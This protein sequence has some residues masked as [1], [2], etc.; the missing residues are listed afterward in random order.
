METLAATLK[1][2]GTVLVATLCGVAVGRHVPN[3]VP[4]MRGIGRFTSLL[5]LP[6]FIFSQL[7]VSMS[8]ELFSHSYLLAVF[9]GL[10]M[11]LQIGIGYLLSFLVAPTHR[12]AVILAVGFPSVVST[13]LSILQS[14][15]GNVPWFTASS[16]QRTIP[17]VLMYDFAATS[18]EWSLGSHLAKRGRK[19]VQPFQSLSMMDD[20]AQR[21]SSYLY[22]RETVAPERV[23][24]E[25]E[26]A[27]APEPARATRWS[28][29]RRALCAVPRLL[30]P[31]LA[32]LLLGS[33][34]GLIPPLSHELQAGHL[35][36]FLQATRFIGD[37]AVPLIITV[38]GCN[39]A[40]GGRPSLAQLNRFTLVCNIGRLI[41]C[42]AV[43]LLL[44]YLLIRA[45]I[46]DS[47]NY[48]V[49]LVMLLE[50]CSPTALATTLLCMQHEYITDD[51]DRMMLIQYILYIPTTTLWLFLV[52][53]QVQAIVDA[54]E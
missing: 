23:M 17:F 39:L 18:I 37:G 8:W 13:P 35:R 14:L 19:L 48:L 51:F 27:G 49:V 40:L 10:C 45:K 52:L 7:V 1:T 25:E 24:E 54:V 5:F 16:F 22:Q 28:A 31:P 43:V 32:A 2:A 3:V 38:L 30:P 36:T 20:E 12:P 4:A 9:G 11:L 50:G 29:V 42:P 41:V 26:P 46:F 34:C 44:V 33:V 53:H 6:C 15:V 21:G 47:S